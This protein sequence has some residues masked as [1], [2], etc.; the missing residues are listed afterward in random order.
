MLQSFVIPPFVPIIPVITTSPVSSLF[1]I[2][3]ACVRWSA[4]PLTLMSSPAHPSLQSHV[5][6]NTCFPELP[7][8][9]VPSGFDKTKW[10]SVVRG[11]K[12]WLDNRQLKEQLLISNDR[13][14]KYI[15]KQKPD[16]KQLLHGTAHWQ[17]NSKHFTTRC[18]IMMYTYT[19][20]DMPTCTNMAGF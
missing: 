5:F 12:Q 9:T 7:T 4:P 18:K 20:E 3:K 17:Q 10:T 19:H 6:N 16:K 13:N 8:A 2:H 14:S 11:V 1:N 15:Y